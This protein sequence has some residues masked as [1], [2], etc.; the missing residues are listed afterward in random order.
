MKTQAENIVKYSI[1]GGIGIFKKDTLKNGITIDQITA[2][3]IE[4]LLLKQNLNNSECLIMMIYYRKQES[5]TSKE[6]AI[7]EFKNIDPITEY[8][9]N[10]QYHTLLIRDFNAYIGSDEKGIQNGDKQNIKKQI[11]V[12][13]FD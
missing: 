10:Q 13:K 1:G 9:Q 11:N 6:E 7:A 2:K 5:G 3:N 4:I 12:K 8:Y